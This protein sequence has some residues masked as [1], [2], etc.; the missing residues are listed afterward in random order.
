MRWGASA[1][2]L[3]QPPEFFEELLT[4]FEE[5]L[6]GGILGSQVLHA[7]EVVQEEPDMPLD[8]LVLIAVANDG[9]L[10]AG[11]LAATEAAPEVSDPRP[12][13]VV[14]GRHDRPSRPAA[15]AQRARRTWRQEHDLG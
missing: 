6:V 13:G 12:D 2:Q 14:A 15:P 9:E 1:D 3:A 10:Q 8:R 7:R 11:E 4:V 5:H